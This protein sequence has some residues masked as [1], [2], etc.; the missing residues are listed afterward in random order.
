MPSVFFFD[1]KLRTGSDSGGGGGAA[2]RAPRA[3]WPP[4]GRAAAAATAG[5]K[6][7]QDGNGRPGGR[8]GFI[9]LGTPT[10]EANY[11]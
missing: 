2:S 11:K 6:G 8:V 7:A 4:S 3:P 1:R 9:Q 10:G 5:A